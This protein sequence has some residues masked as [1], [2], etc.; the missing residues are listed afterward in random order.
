ML[1]TKEVPPPQ[2][3]NAAMTFAEYLA[4]ELRAASLRARLLSSEIDAIAVA[5]SGG[6]VTAEQALTLMAGVDLLRVI[7]EQ[8]SDE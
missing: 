2:G 5:L 3:Q 4:A 6:L 1:D 7:G 8:S